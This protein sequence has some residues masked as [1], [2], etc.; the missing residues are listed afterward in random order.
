MKEEL[1]PIADRI[2]ARYAEREAEITCR[3]L[4]ELADSRKANDAVVKE[5]LEA[6]ELPLMTWNEQNHKNDYGIIW[7]HEK[8]ID[9][10]LSIIQRRRGGK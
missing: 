7:S 9:E 2:L 5:I 8:A 3:W 6:I 4:K 10:A 1:G